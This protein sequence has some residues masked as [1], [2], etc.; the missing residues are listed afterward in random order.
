[1]AQ[2]LTT[3]EDELVMKLL[4]YFITEG[5]YTPI[6]L[7]GAN[8]EIWL[9]NFD[10]EYKIVR[11]VS[12]YIHN[13]E[14][15]EV[16]LLKTKQIM[17]S[18][19]KKT[20]SPSLNTLSIFINLGDNVEFNKI[21]IDDNIMCADVK[22]LSDLKKY[23]FITE[24]FPDIINKTKFSEKGMELF[25]KI[26]GEI[27]IKSEK[28]AEKAEDVFKPKKPYITYGILLI[29]LV[30]FILTFFYN[31]QNGNGLIDSLLGNS[32]AALKTFGGLEPSLVK[33]G[34][35][36]RLITS[37]FNHIGLF[38]LLF[39]SYAL[40]VIGSQLESYIGRTKYLIIY[41]ASAIFGNLLSVALV[42]GW[43]AGASGAIFGLLGA[44]LYFGYHY[45]VYLGTVIK[46]QIIPLI[47]INLTIGFLSPEINNAAHI[48][49]LIGGFLGLQ[50][51]GVKYKSTKTDK[52]NGIILLTIYTGFLVYISFFR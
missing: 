28:N 12:N 7:H 19:S 18:I 44:L 11:I 8:N 3:K 45:R 25:A 38:H 51:L 52:I 15:F 27:T 32:H 26:T 6:V 29:N 22:K 4:H 21:E 37:A 23:D 36:Y 5:D 46:S 33:S 50:A 17:H 41:L 24:I 30:I 16:D 10:S 49:G 34:Q 47:L 20:L 2:S 40:Y 48:G 9:E 39:N 1:M 43:S 31:V 13:N 35:Y 14:Q 42:S